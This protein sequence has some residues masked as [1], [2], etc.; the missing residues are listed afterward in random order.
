M[1]HASGLAASIR[2]ATES[3][4]FDLGGH[5]QANITQTIEDAFADPLPL[6]EMIRI[7]FVTGAGKLGRQ[8]YDENAAKAL[9]AALRSLGYEEDRGASCVVE[10]GGSFKLQHD[11][12]KNLKTVVVFPKI[13]GSQGGAD[14]T[15][16]EGGVGE[17]SVGERALLPEG[18]PEQMITMSS[19]N[20]FQRMLQSKCQS[21]AQKKGCLKALDSVKTML[22]S[23]EAKLFSGTPLTDPEQELYDSISL[24]ALVEKEGLVK[25]LM[26]AQVESGNITRAERETLLSQVEEKIE[27]FNEEIATARKENKPKRE[28]KMTQMKEKAIIR[29]KMLE[30]TVPKAPQRLRHE[31]EIA[32]LRTELSPLQKLEDNAKGRLLSVKETAT[33]ARKDEILDEISQL[34]EASRGW[35]E[36]DEVFMA[37]VEA[38][39][40][41]AN[42]KEKQKSRKPASAGSGYKAKPV[43]SWVTPASSKK[44]AP[45]RSSAKSKAASSGGMFAAMMMDSDS[46]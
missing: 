40:S 43:A 10:C 29:Q 16:L 39:R 35:F 15:G 30:D 14:E 19:S 42:A 28:E 33:L 7:T 32:K 6:A 12:G 46:D 26:Q 22:E 27:K 18:S 21:W 45:A 4:T 1:S 13:V 41:S 24:D 44:K 37:R 17:L 3:D 31:A 36:E 20:V 11:T 38:S 23:L 34:E 9:T 25:K 5:T 2:G 8:K